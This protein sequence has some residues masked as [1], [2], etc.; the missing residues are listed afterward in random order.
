M[1]SLLSG[2]AR[3]CGGG[4]ALQ[5]GAQLPFASDIYQCWRRRRHCNYNTSRAYVRQTLT[6]ELRRM[7]RQL[8]IIFKSFL[9]YCIVI[10]W[11]NYTKCIVF[12]LV[13]TIRFASHSLMVNNISI[14]KYLSKTS[15]LSFN[16]A[17]RPQNT[18]ITGITVDFSF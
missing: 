2:Y 14:T 13:V 1:L 15:K 7:R 6:L 12:A 8:Y 16:I 10:Y 5:R 11:H 4:L 17:S 9:W 3:G 18:Y